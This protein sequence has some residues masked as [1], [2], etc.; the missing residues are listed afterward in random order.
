MKTIVRKLSL[1][2]ETLVKKT[3][4]PPCCSSGE[5]SLVQ[6]LFFDAEV[7]ANVESTWESFADDVAASF[8]AT[9]GGLTRVFPAE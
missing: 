2:I 6:Q 8:V 7:T 9:N 3:S 1:Q 4:Y 5:V